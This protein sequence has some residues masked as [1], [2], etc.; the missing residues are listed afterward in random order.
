MA[1]EG[2]VLAPQGGGVS[3]QFLNR[4]CRNCT[5]PCQGGEKLHPKRLGYVCSHSYCLCMGFEP[6]KGAVLT[7]VLVQGV[8]IKT[9][10]EGLKRS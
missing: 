7:Q 1:P 8:Y 4:A 3:K 5:P 6:I 9:R 10:H 2:A